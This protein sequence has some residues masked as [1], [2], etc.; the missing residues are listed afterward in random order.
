MSTVL[1]VG[2]SSRRSPLHDVY[3]G[4]IGDRK[5]T[6]NHDLMEQWQIRF[7]E[8]SR[9]RSP[10]LFSFVSRRRTVKSAPSARTTSMSQ[11]SGGAPMP[12][13]PTSRRHDN[14]RDV[15][16]IIC[17]RAQLTEIPPHTRAKIG[18]LAQ[19]LRPARPWRPR[20][21]LPSPS[22]EVRQRLPELR[23]EL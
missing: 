7:R 16:P 5:P 18:E 1:I 9:V 2:V 19:P 14:I 11:G 17:A 21:L 8:I 20:L 4:N 10:T 6:K 15:P 3:E 12:S 13:F 22:L 23:F